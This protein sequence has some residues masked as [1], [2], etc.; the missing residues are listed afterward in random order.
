MIKRTKI[1]PKIEWDIILLFGKKNNV[2]QNMQK[3][4]LPLS[5]QHANDAQVHP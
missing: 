3:L 4:Q 1:F 5:E 2:D